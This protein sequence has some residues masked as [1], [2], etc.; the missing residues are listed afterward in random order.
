[1]GVGGGDELAVGRD[2]R[3]GRDQV[4]DRVEELAGHHAVIDDHDRESGRSVVEDQGAGVQPVTGGGAGGLDEPAVDD[5]GEPLGGDVDG[6]GPGPQRR[7][8][9]LPG[10]TKHEQEREDQQACHDGTR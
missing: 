7:V 2:L 4:L 8:G 1:M 5:D 3:L 9:R 6:R 10:G